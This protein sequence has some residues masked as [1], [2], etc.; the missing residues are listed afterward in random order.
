MTTNRIRSLPSFGSPLWLRWQPCRV[1]V[2]RRVRDAWRKPGPA[3]MVS[4]AAAKRTR[5]LLGLSKVSEM[6]PGPYLTV[7]LDK[8]GGCRTVHVEAMRRYSG[9][10]YLVPETFDTERRTRAGVEIRAALKARA[11]AA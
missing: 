8:G 2:G 5:Q 1:K 10:D 9:P 11:R 4:A 6:P 3:T 7:M